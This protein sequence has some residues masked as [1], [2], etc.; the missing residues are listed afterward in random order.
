MMESK[1]EFFYKVSKVNG[2]EYLQIWKRI[3]GSSKDRSVFVMS[4]GTAKKLHNV[5][6]RANEKDL[7]TKQIGETLTNFSEGKKLDSD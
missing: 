2:K 3:N 5:L 1:E 6:V 7:L 4:C